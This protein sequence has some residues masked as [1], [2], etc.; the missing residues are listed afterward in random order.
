MAKEKEHHLA[1]KKSKT[2]TDSKGKETSPPPKAKKAKPIN[3]A[4]PR[5]IPVPKLGEGHLANPAT[6]LGPRASFL[7]SPSVAE[8]ILSRVGPPTNKEKVEQLT[9]DQIVTRFYHTIGGGVRFFFGHLE[10]GDGRRGD[11]STRSG[12]VLGGRG[13]LRL[14]AKSKILVAELHDSVVHS[15]KLVVEAFKSS[16]E[17]LD[18]VET[19]TTKYFGEGFDICKLQLR[20]HHPELAID[21][22]GMVLDHDLLDEEERE[23][24]QGEAEAEAEVEKKKEDE[25]TSPFS[26]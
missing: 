15:K 19:T 23:E 12:W 1:H 24:E 7:G 10:Q 2:A 13:D 8:K 9:L 11:P 22:K 18:A 20:L 25:A 26:P 6:A 3:A 16:G 17:F 5:A 4:S 21:L 14:E